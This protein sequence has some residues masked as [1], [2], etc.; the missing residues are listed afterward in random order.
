MSSAW[1]PRGLSGPG[2]FRADQIPEGSPYELADGHPILRLPPSERGRVFKLLGGE[3]LGSD[4]AVVSAGVDLGYS[5]GP[6]DLR[7]LD[8]AVGDFPNQPGWASVAPPLAVEYADTGQDER[9][10]QDKIHELLSAGTKHIWVVRLVGPRRVEV[11]EPGKAMRL[12]L[13]GTD[14]L[15][16]GILQNPVPVLA[17][18]DRDAAHEATLRNL[19]QRKGFNS[20]DDV[21]AEGEARGEARGEAK[22]RQEALVT[23]LGA[24]KLVVSGAQ[25]ERILAMS[26][27]ATLDQWIVLATTAQS[28]AAVI[29]GESTVAKRQPSGAGPE[30][31]P[32]GIT[33]RRGPP[34]RLRSAGPP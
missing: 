23:L 26:N 22:G 15:A 24:R 6:K 9:D 18:F 1:S 17:L 10:L 27:S 25:R 8:V 3:V 13:P 14:L 28:T 29:G 5:S 4:P 7:A 12:A 20:L 2:P 33:V 21:R 31:S 34:A 16:P 30:R 19:L 32:P 11:H